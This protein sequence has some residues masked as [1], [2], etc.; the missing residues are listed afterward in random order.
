MFN[1][2]QLIL[3][4]AAL[5][6]ASRCAANPLDQSINDMFTN[7]TS[8][9][10]LNNNMRGAVYGGSVYVRTPNMVINP[11]A[12]DLPRFSAGCGG[13]DATMGAFSWIS[14]DKLMQF[15]R[16]IIQ[17]A[18]P[19][20]FDMALQAFSPTIAQILS[21]FQHLAQSM[22]NFSMNSCQ[23]ATSLDKN[24]ASA[25][26]DPEATANN[27]GSAVS[28]VYNSAKGAISDFTEGFDNFMSD[29]SQAFN[30][31]LKNMA[32]DNNGNKYVVAKNVGNITWN[33]LT[34]KQNALGFDFYIDSDPI[35]SKEIIMTVLGTTIYAPT[36]MN[37]DTSKPD[38]TTYKSD[39]RFRDIVEDRAKLGTGQITVFV[40]DDTN[41]CLHPAK[42]PMAYTGINGYVRKMMFGD[43]QATSAQPGS[44]VDI[45]G[46]GCSGASGTACFS[47]S[48]IAFLNSVANVPVIGILRHAQFNQ[49]LLN[50]VA[51]KLID[52][53][54]ADVASIYGERFIK[55]VRSIYQGSVHTPPDDYQE[56]LRGLQ[57][58]VAYYRQQFDNDNDRIEKVVREV[59]RA[60]ST[61]PE[62]VSYKTK[63]ISAKN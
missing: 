63:R 61:M 59:D 32:T 13:I 2:K 15:A 31:M 53:V 42:T 1:K 9:G 55:V 10:T 28:G 58:D 3:I 41:V 5:A 39:L 8:P 40:C 49:A 47:S 46:S 38:T 43:A 4:L 17:Q 24:I 33:A 57:E 60:Y 21:K 11:I 23:M 22:N 7:V 16:K 44:I 45:M 29:P 27:I 37:D 26:S 48:Q 20:A 18:V 62:L 19:V 35:L 54:V 6:I 25:L 52:V 12:V 56:T 51:N 50:S 36:N 30:N 14:A 34:F